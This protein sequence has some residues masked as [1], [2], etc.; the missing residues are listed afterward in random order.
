MTQ[1]TNLSLHWEINKKQP[2]ATISICNIPI[3]VIIDS[4]ST[5]ILINK[6]T[7]KVLKQNS[8]TLN[9]R[10]SNAKIYP[11]GTEK[12]L[13]VL[14]EFTTTITYK[15]HSKITTFYVIKGSTKCLLSYDLSMTLGLLKTF[16]NTVILQHSNPYVQELLNKHRSLFQ[17]MSKLK[18]RE[19]EP[20]IDESISP[21]A[22]H[23]RIIPHSMKLKEMHKQDIIEKVEG[24]TPWLSPL[25][26]IPKES[27][28]I[29]LVLD[30]M[31][32]T[33]VFTEV[34]L[35]QGYLQIPLA[36][37]SRYITAF[38]T[39]K[40]GL[41]R[42]KRL[43]MGACPSGEYFHEEIHNIIRDALNCANISDN[44]WL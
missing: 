15:L 20:E 1:T 9:L 11:Y 5:V 41:H 34:D 18:G 38:P 16:V 22:Q 44:I 28:D 12:P 14:G 33:S 43:V 31:H 37:E 6:A 40:D 35:S 23:A 8:H 17:G 26:A 19:I 4:G 21:I 7:F 32:G 29:R 39:P 27:G 13:E 42:F 2:Q 3:R 24:V 30:K 25:I 36:E 10:R